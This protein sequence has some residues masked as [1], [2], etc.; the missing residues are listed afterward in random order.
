MTAIEILIKIS[1]K[2]KCYNGENMLGLHGV[3]IEK[4]KI[5]MSINSTF[6]QTTEEL[7]LII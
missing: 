2:S 1:K 5:F 6:M 7:Y 3:G 4:M